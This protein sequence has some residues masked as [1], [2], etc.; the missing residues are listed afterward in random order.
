MATKIGFVL[1]MGGA[2]GRPTGPQLRA[3]ARTPHEKNGLQPTNLITVG[4]GQVVPGGSGGFAEVPCCTPARPNMWHMIKTNDWW[5]QKGNV[6][7]TTGGAVTGG[8]LGARR[9]RC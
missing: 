8:A 2:G 6:N 9:R 1:T 4:I 7:S 3:C 5:Y